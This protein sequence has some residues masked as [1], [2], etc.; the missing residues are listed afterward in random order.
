MHAFALRLLSPRTR[1]S[2]FRYLHQTLPS[3]NI[4]FKLKVI[5]SRFEHLKNSPSIYM[6][7]T[8]SSSSS[9]ASRN[10]ISKGPS[11]YPILLAVPRPSPTI[12]GTIVISRS[13]SLTDYSLNIYSKSSGFM[14]SPSWF[15]TP[16]TLLFASI[17]GLDLPP[18]IDGTLEMIKLTGSP[19]R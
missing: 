18:Y 14:P 6:K 7:D 15:L 4:G 8:V 12:F 17:Q 9:P 5:D 16:I 2:I 13:P 1:E 19:L 3:S 11:A 10:L